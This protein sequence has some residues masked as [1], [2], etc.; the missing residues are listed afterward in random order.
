MT[1]EKTLLALSVTAVLTA[2]GGG[3]GGPKEYWYVNWSFSRCIS[4]VTACEIRK[5][6]P[7]FSTEA[8]C[9][10]SSTYKNTAGLPSNAYVGCVH[11]TTL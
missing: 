2:C 10:N 3:D 1:F 4:G 8:E 9:I 6:D 11:V 7:I 5:F